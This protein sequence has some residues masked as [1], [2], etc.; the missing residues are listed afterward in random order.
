MTDKNWLDLIPA[1]QVPFYEE[2]NLIS[3]KVPKTRNKLIKKIINYLNKDEHK[4]MHL[5]AIGSR[6][7]E[8]MDGQRSIGEII[9]DLEKEFSDEK[10]LEQRTILFCNALFKEKYILLYKKET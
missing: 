7:W 4:I 10:Q 2:G 3:L 1:R 5:D 8:K 6:V 9:S